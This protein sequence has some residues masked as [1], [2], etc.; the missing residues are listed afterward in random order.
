MT[1]DRRVELTVEAD[2]KSLQPWAPVENLHTSTQQLGYSA[3]L[4]LRRTD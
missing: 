2:F 3:P 1:R 4:V